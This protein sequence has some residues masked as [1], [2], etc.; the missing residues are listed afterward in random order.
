MGRTIGLALLAAACLAGCLH[1][2]WFTGQATMLPDGTIHLDLA[3]KDRSGTI[4]HGRI[5]YGPEH[6]DYA[7][8]K[9]HVGEISVGEVKAIAPFPEKW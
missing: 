4:V 5:D 1:E 2:P 6:P 7:Q 9:A 8:V 3:S